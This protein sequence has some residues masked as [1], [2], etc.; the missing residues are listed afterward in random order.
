MSRQRIDLTGRIFG[1]LQV[2]KSDGDK[3]SGGSIIWICKCICGQFVSVASRDLLHSSNTKSCGCL[4][5]DHIKNLEKDNM[6]RHAVDG[7]FVPLLNQKIQTNS[8]TGI[9]G[10]SI[11]HSKSGKVRYIANITLNNKRHYLGIFNEL[12][13][14][15][16]ARKMAEEK[17]FKPYIDKHGKGD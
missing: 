13:D 10:V 17:Y 1:R 8:V 2:I 3:L 6:K 9:K 14:A 7:V 16:T 5:S 15:V 4:L 11:R 12:A